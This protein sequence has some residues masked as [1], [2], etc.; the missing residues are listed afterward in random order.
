MRKKWKTDDRS[1]RITLR[2]APSV[3]AEA[4]ALAEQLGLDL[5]GFLNLVIRRAL[6]HYRMEARLLRQE[7]ELEKDL[8]TNW[9]HANP[10]RPA[11]EFWDEYWRLQQATQQGIKEAV[12][13]EFDNQ[14][15]AAVAAL[16]AQSLRAKGGSHEQPKT[17]R[18]R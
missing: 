1:G 2:M 10:G 5:N 9:L 6:P 18:T 17:P 13:F 3:H 8:I 4:A 7:F 15:G 12:E 14:E 16:M 11:R